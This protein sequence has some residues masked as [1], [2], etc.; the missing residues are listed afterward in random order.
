MRLDKL[1]IPLEVVTHSNSFRLL[2]VHPYFKYEENERTGEIIGYKYTVGDALTFDQLDIKVP[3]PATIQP[4]QLAAAKVPIDV[5]FLNCIGKPY[6]RNNGQYEIS[7][8][9]DAVQVVQ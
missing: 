2:S 8:S 5:Q 1:R 7:F 6:R 9:A 4:E 3:G